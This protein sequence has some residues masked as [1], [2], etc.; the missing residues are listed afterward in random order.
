MKKKYA[1]EKDYGDVPDADAALS[2]KAPAPKE[3]E[4][5]TQ[6]AKLC[7][8]LSSCGIEHETTPGKISFV[9]GTHAG[10]EGKHGTVATF[11]HGDDGK[12]FR[13]TLG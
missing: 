13:V 12:I 8:V 2:A 3:Y 11:E 1:D 5:N 6:C 7:G 9:V 4:Q 10:V